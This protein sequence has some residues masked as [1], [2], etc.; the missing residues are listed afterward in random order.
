MC[1]CVC[2]CVYVFVCDFFYVAV[3]DGL[4]KISDEFRRIFNRC[5]KLTK[6]F[7]MSARRAEKF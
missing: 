6:N 7:K 1:V 4:F 3:D 5:R 2:V